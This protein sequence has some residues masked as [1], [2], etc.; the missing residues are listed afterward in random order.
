M[1][2]Y[3]LLTL[4][5]FQQKDYYYRN[6]NILFSFFRFFSSLYE[7]KVNILTHSD[8]LLHFLFHRRKKIAHMSLMWCALSTLNDNIAAIVLPFLNSFGFVVFVVHLCWERKSV[9]ILVV[10]FYTSSKETA[11]D[12]KHSQRSHQNRS[13][14]RIEKNFN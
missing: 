6:E 12:G 1:Y 3:F 2:L 4:R 14:G 5:R 11:V 7:R 13:R 10:F 8:V 9:C